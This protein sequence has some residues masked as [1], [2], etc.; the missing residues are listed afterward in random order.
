MGMP[1]KLSDE[2]VKLARKEAEAA[3]RSLT[4]QIEHWAKLGRSVETALR[5]QEVMALKGAGGDLHGAFPDVSVR[6]TIHTVLQRIAGATN[7][8]ELARTLTHGRVVYQSDPGGSELIMRIEPDGQRTLGRFE[9]RQF[10]PSGRTRSRR[11]AR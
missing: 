3:D 4:A 8:A 10:V 2:L 7:R 1:V 6:R 11:A 9:K 5:H